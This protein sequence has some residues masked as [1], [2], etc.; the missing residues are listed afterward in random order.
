MA[1]SAIN[2]R[3]SRGAHQ[4]LDG[5][6]A[7]RRCQLPEHSQAHY[8]ADAAPRID[9][10]PVKITKSQPGTRAYGAAGE[11]AEQERKASHV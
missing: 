5:F 2:R 1:Y 3:E 10:G 8:V 9:Y 4:R 6:E 11:K 7:A